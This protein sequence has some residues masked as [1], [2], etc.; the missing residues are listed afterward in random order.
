MQ[1]KQEPRPH[2]W[3]SYLTRFK[4][5]TN[6]DGEEFYI[7]QMSH[8]DVLCPIAVMKKVWEEQLALGN[9]Y[10]LDYLQLVLLTGFLA[11]KAQLESKGE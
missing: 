4:S 2:G 8:G 9:T 6:P 7:A 1:L 11:I 10:A 5:H 3:D